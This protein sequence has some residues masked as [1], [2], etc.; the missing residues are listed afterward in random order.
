MD[1]R[2]FIFT[3]AAAAAAA[4]VPAAKADSAA[5]AG[6]I[7]EL[8]LA[9]IAAAFSDGRLSALQLTEM[10]LTRIDELDRRGPAL[11]AVIEINARARETA[12]ALDLERR[13]RGP[14]GP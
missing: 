10:Y 9:D 7:D 14:R 4:A 12:A 3:A 6:A 8:S 13:S 5:P 1:R 11:R 2:N